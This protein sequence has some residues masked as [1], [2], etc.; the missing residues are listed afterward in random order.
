MYTKI[1]YKHTIIL[2]EK[3]FNFLLVKIVTK[4]LS[5]V[6]SINYSSFILK[7]RKKILFK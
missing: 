1:V 4:V 5:I 6:K 3:E 7:F 2:E